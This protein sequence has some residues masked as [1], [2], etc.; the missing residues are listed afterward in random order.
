MLIESDLSKEE[1]GL[2][3][4]TERL[5]SAFIEGKSS[6]LVEEPTGPGGSIASKGTSGTKGFDVAELERRIRAE[7]RIIGLLGDD[8]VSSLNKIPTS[9]AHKPIL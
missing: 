8:E 5:M 7:L 9:L 6:S 4:V 1:K 2:G 3:P